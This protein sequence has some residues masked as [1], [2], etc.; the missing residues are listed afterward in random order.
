MELLQKLLSTPFEFLRDY[1]GP[2][3]L[4]LSILVFVHEWGHYIVA[5]M[6]G[7]K[8]ESFSIGFGKEIFGRT[9]KNGTRWKF[10]LIPLGGYVQMFGDI[11]PASTQKA[12]GVTE[13]DGIRPFTADEKKVAFYSQS[14]ARRA[15]IVIAGPLVNYIFAIILLSG[16]YIFEGQPYTPPVAAKVIE[17]GPA[18]KAGLQLDDRIV[19]INGK[20]INRF[21]DIGLMV[22]I[23]LDKELE[24]ELA[25]YLGDNKWSEETRKIK[26][27]PQ[28][29]V[30]EDRFGFKHTTGRIG[31]SVPGKNTDMKEHTVV[32]GVGAAFVEVYEITKS[33]MKALGQMIMGFRSADELGG[34]LR[35]G[36]YAG[37][38]A[39]AGVIALITFA[40]LLSV[41]LGFINLLPIPML[42]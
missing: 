4:V 35:I 7:V 33:T 38:F 42:D 17:G 19:T 24:I 23:N 2:F 13:A 3:V 15:A 28:R 36:A 29:I 22:A 20:Q 21:Q 18:Y 37:Q 41:N 6:C 5:R 30:E 34:I 25:K 14:V 8:I 16:L 27:T 11:D 31:I 39:E 9:D 32:S 12:E 26:V 10:S 40:A 1:G